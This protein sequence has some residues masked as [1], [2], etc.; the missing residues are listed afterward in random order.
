[1][2]NKYKQLKEEKKQ[3]KKKKRKVVDYSRF[4]SLNQEHNSIVY[5][6]SATQKFAETHNM[7]IVEH[8]SDEAFSGTTVNRPG[9]MQMI[10]EAKNKPIWD[11]VLVFDMSRFSRNTQDAITYENI[12]NDC[13][14]ELISVTE[15]YDNTP[16]GEYNK[17]IQTV[18]NQQYS[19]TL[20]YRTRA[21]MKSKAA[22][23]IWLGGHIPL[24]FELGP[25]RRLKVCPEEAEIIRRVFDL[26]EQGNSYQMI[27]DALNS[28][29]HT[30][31]LGKPFTKGS[32]RDI[33]KS[34]RYAGTV[35]WNRRKEKD[36]NGKRNGSAEKD[37]SEQVVLE[38]G[39]SIISEEQ[40][41]RVQEM[42]EERSKGNG[43]QVLREHYMLGAKKLLR[44]AECGKFM[45][46][47]KVSSHG[48]KYRVYRCPNHKGGGCPTK[49]IPAD[50][51][52]KFVAICTAKAVLKKED[53]E[54]MNAVCEYGSSART[55]RSKLRGNSTSTASLMKALENCYS[56]AIVDR[57]A[58]LEVERKSLEKQL[59]LAE[60]PS[61][62]MTEDNLKGVRK[63]MA[64]Y[65]KD[66]M[67]PEAGLLLKAAINEIIVD[68]DGAEIK[69]NV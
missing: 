43:G 23:G 54:N 11:A 13:G 47:T 65:L 20:G 64:H 59:E 12:L 67:D 57:L 21:G 51:L 37:I 55:I 63:K 17:A 6:Q 45:V 49:D 10:N 8:F 27:A 56:E 15:L 29:K 35:V 36:R 52:E 25:D 46:G 24:G 31:R 3:K 32:F 60:K 40:F 50:N 28:E 68:N 62:V 53:I 48:K 7:E 61:F 26:Y 34:P 38:G 66:S 5:Q 14:I 2:V 42:I 19:R 22:E 44:C 16:A 41:D 33:L 58:R 1:M 39:P 4:S 69:L 9:F 30:N 18:N